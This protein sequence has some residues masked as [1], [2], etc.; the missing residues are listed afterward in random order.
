MVQE[1]VLEGGREA[2]EGLETRARIYRLYSALYEVSLSRFLHRPVL[3]RPI[4]S[5]PFFRSYPYRSNAIYACNTAL[6]LH[7]PS[8]YTSSSSSPSE[9]DSKSDPDSTSVSTSLSAPY[10]FLLNAPNAA[11][12]S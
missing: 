12:V 7:T 8:S 11:A 9:G 4:V 5:S 6:R 1:R 10:L 3:P 2:F